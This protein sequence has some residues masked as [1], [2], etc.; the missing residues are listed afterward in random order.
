MQT[1]VFAT[2]N[3]DK[4]REAEEILGYPVEIQKLALDEIQ[5][6]S[7][8][9]VVRK[10]VI[11]AYTLVKRPVIV[12]DVGV[13]VDVWN[14]FPGPFIKFVEQNNTNDLLLYMMRNETNRNVQIVSA[15]GFCDGKRTEIFFGEKNGRLSIESRGTNGWGFDPVFIPQGYDKTWAEMGS[16]MKNSMSHR[17]ASLERLSDF[18][19][20]YWK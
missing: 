10:K 13:Y 15:I 8:E 6:D 20:D 14:G 1:L 5:S 4:A 9:V 17:K 3:K 7:L 2:S 12:D 18:L 16:E 19:R 11:D